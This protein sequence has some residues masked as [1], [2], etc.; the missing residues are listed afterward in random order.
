MKLENYELIGIRLDNSFVVTLKFSNG[1]EKEDKTFTL[2]HKQPMFA[3]DFCV[4]SYVYH[5]FDLSE[6]Y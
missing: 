3:I 5:D 6:K 2:H 4:A 1:I